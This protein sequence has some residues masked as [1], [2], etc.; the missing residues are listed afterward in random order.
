MY[1]CVCVSYILNCL[2]HQIFLIGWFYHYHP[3][4]TTNNYYETRGTLH[5]V[6]LNEFIQQTIS[7]DDLNL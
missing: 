4:T 1:M 2:F 3:L 5:D 6:I 7:L